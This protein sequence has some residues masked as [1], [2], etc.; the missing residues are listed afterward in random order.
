MK[1]ETEKLITEIKRKQRASKRK[2][3][4][5]EIR[6]KILN[7]LQGGGHIAP[8]M[9]NLEAINEVDVLEWDGDEYCPWFYVVHLQAVWNVR[10]DIDTKIVRDFYKRPLGK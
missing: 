10:F 1:T 3:I 7:L 6:S 4:V 8:L 5:G 2:V 9:K